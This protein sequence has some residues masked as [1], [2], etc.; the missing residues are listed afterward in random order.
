MQSSDCKGRSIHTAPRGA[1]PWQRE[2]GPRTHEIPSLSSS[3]TS[4]SIIA[5]LSSAQRRRD[6][7][8]SKLG[9]IL[10]Y[11]RTSLPSAS[12]CSRIGEKSRAILFVVLL[13]GSDLLLLHPS[14][15]LRICLPFNPEITKKNLSL[16]LVFL[17]DA[18]ARGRRWG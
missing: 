12:K 10:K 17:S 7:A 1:L 9:V 8:P 11:R 16:L 18:E 13:I 15:Y 4:R 2:E 3:S 5:V 6:E 14:L